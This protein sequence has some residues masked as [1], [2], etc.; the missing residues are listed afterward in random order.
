MP[1]KYDSLGCTW[2]TNGKRC[3]RGVVVKREDDWLCIVCYR[4]VESMLG[5]GDAEPVTVRSV[6]P[7]GA[8]DFRLLLIRELEAELIRAQAEIERLKALAPQ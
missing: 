6:V 1:K 5:I 3:H 8:P 2:K 7:V 4:F